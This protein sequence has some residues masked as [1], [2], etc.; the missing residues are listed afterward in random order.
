MQIPTALF[1]E[2]GGP[3]PRLLAGAQVGRRGPSSSPGK[4]TECAR[5]P[6]L[7]GVGASHGR[8]HQGPFY[9]GG[10]VFANFSS[11]ACGP[12]GIGGRNRTF[13]GLLFSREIIA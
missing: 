5:A 4:P 12:R 6:W 1:L 7:P 13:E 9:P 11:R 3:P 10:W 2:W 8:R